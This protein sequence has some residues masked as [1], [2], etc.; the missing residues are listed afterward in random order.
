[1]RH[2]PEAW[3]QLYE[4]LLGIRPTDAATGV[5]QDIHWSQGMFGNFPT[6]TL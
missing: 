6:Y 4:E 3:D 2:L 5:L 1:M